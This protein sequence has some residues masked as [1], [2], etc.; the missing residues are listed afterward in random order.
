[1][2]KILHDYA[3]ACSLAFDF[4][5]SCVH[6]YFSCWIILISVLIMCV[7][8]ILLSNSPLFAVERKKNQESSTE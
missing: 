4:S 7:T 3:S 8:V 1:M 5:M 2:G 6:I